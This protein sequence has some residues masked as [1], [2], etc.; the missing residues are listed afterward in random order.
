MSFTDQMLEKVPPH[1]LDAEMAVLG[2][3]LLSPDAVLKAMELIR[4]EA[5]YK[6]AHRI[7]FRV[8]VE[9]FDRGAPVD[10][11]VIADELKKRN[12][13]EKVGGV[14][15]VAS[16]GNMVPTA[17]HVDHYISIVFEKY[18]LRS[19]VNASTSIVER[20][21][22]HDADAES[23]LD[24]AEH[25]IFEIAQKKVGGNFSDTKELIKNTIQI[26]E[27]AVNNKRQVTGLSTGY[28]DLDKQTSG[29]QKSDLIVIAARPS[30]GKT[31]LSLNIVEHVAIAEHVPVAVFSLEMSKEQL[32]QRMLCSLARIDF[33][34][35]RRGF[36]SRTEWPALLD[37][38]SKLSESKI[39][40]D[41]TP[42]VSVME[43]RAK[44]R[45]LKAS[46]NIGFIVIDYL[47]L[48]Q[49][50]GKRVESRQQEISEISRSLKSLARELHVPVVVLSQ[51]NRSV[52]SRQDHRPMLSDLRESGA[53]EQDADVVMMMLRPEYY[54][55]EVRPG[56]A[57][58]IIAKQRNGPVGD[59]TLRFFSEYARFENFISRDDD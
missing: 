12:K 58:V 42:G 34:K 6:E 32:I 1:N 43:L 14:S 31:A 24:S 30:M 38:A 27:E 54:D 39:F 57:D 53:I 55:R 4:E 51:L 22:A 47:Q 9:L 19:L 16:L 23:L 33:S 25:Q 8:V 48:M 13:L 49:S 5:F 50:S 26:I 52:E 41:D 10:M 18:L 15:Y 7:I 37:A 56:E 20:C 44:A 59:I 2:A 3:M 45:R 28:V 21:Y 36:L 46:D 40:I 17:A 11:V 29:F 35:V